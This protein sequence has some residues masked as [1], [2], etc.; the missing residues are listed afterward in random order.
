MSLSTT[1]K[2]SKREPI[3]DRR[4]VMP[5]GKFR[6]RTIEFLMDAEPLYLQ[7]LLGKE[8]IEF[9]YQLQ[10][11]FEQMNPWLTEAKNAHPLDCYEWTH[12]QND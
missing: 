11:E 9:D 12:T 8:I 10:D 6:G 4:F 3:T 7:W 1:H 5:F 2:E